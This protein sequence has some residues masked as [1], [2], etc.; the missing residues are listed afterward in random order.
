MLRF[1]GESI[2]NLCAWGY[3]V[4]SERSLREMFGIVESNKHELN[5]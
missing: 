1:V 5:T 3:G 4:V 2:R